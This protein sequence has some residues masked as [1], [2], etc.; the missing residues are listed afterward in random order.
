MSL[1][2]TETMAAFEAGWGHV[3]GGEPCQGFYIGREH[4]GFTQVRIVQSVQP[5]EELVDCSEGQPGYIITKGGHVMRGYVNQPALTK[6]AVTEDGWYLK[7]GDI[8]FFLGPERDLYW[9]SRDSQMLI[10]GGSN[11]AFEQVNAELAQFIETE[12][13]LPRSSFNVAVC[14]LRV[15]SE[16]EDE[17]C[18]MIELLTEQSKAAQDIIESTFLAAARLVVS[19]GSKPDR[20]AVGAI[21]VLLSKGIVSVPELVAYWKSQ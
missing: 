14:G 4:T 3:W 20:M 8:G 7:L 18:V 19:K 6:D 16:H 13:S 15:K 12:Y 11:Y 17:C 2:Y 5:L 9:Q 1:S 21:P 10:R